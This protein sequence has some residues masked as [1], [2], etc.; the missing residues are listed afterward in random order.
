MPM[1]RLLATA[2]LMIA[3]PA[4]ASAGTISIGPGQ[5]IQAAIQGAQAGDR[6]ELLPG[7]YHEAIDFLGKSIAVVGVGGAGVTILDGT[8]LGTSIVTFQSQEGPLALLEG[9]TLSGAS[10][11]TF[12]GG[13]VR[14][15]NGSDPTLR[16]CRFVGNVAPKGGGMLVA[17]ASATIEHCLFE[18][19]AAT[20][21]GGFPSL[22]GGGILFYGG[23]LKVRDCTFRQNVGGAVHAD[24]S[25][26]IQL[27]RS[28]FE[29][30]ATHEAVALNFVS[31]T[32]EDCVFVRNSARGLLVSNYD[33]V[34]VR[35]SQFLDNAHAETGGGAR[36]YTGP[37]FLN[38]QVILVES[39]VFAR[40]QAP[41]GSALSVFNNPEVGF[42]PPPAATAIESC[43]FS[44]NGP[45]AAIHND[46]ENALIHGTIVRG[47]AGAYTGGP[48][49]LVGY[50]N[51]EGGA[52]GPGNMDADPLFVD[53][54]A[55]DLH[56]R[57]GSP[58]LAAADPAGPL[59]VDVD[60]SARDPGG[61]AEVGAD[62]RKP[63]LVFSGEQ[64][65]GELVRVALH[66]QPAP[67]AVY[68]LLSASATSGPGALKL[69]PPIFVFV[70]PGLA[71][72]GFLAF[73]ATVPAGIQPLTV[74][75]QAWTGGV[76][77][78]LAS[79]HLW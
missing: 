16:H 8:G 14:C 51:I 64:G 60:G 61:L 10:S 29:D 65:A 52:A 78:P 17:N 67:G 37:N 50:S 56:L 38:D 27:L 25:G 57:I 30:H 31:P 18:G 43:T 58:C 24:L 9:V 74:H 48:G 1:L 68:L 2:A 3:L 11:T 15:V 54:A 44:A 21:F 63:A 26:S 73:T 22:P 19:N 77:T 53:P 5:S 70:L 4:L 79:L 46:G 12:Q 34:I 35:R 47:A 69:G 36:L 71:P 55:D 75:A 59:P 23:D 13:G 28:R 45:G 42:D 20:H 66:G 49:L 39:C 41:E 72:A 62:E 33:D 76:L 32:I 7:T 6:I 40:N